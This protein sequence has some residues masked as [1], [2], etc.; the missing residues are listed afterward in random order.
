MSIKKTTALL[1]R[2]A[3]TGCLLFY[4]LCGTPGSESDY[5][6]EQTV[7]QVSACCG[8]KPDV[9]DCSYR[10]VNVGSCEHPRYATYY[11]DV[12]KELGLCIQAKGCEEVRAAGLCDVRAWEDL[13]NC[14]AIP[15]ADMSLPQPSAC[16]ALE[17]L[18]CAP[19]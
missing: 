16:A 18:G 1:R 3:S 12:N 19:G 17:R 10:T 9:V 5:Y 14:G 7:A 4:S 6:C 8:R 15:R 13:F 11:A 2:I